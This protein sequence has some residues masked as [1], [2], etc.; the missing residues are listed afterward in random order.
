MKDGADLA[1]LIEDQLDAIQS[2]SSSLETNLK[3]QVEKDNT[4]ML[5]AYDELQK[6]VILLKVDMMQ[7]LSISVDYVDSDGD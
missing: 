4:K 1:S 7:A 2:Q 5:E 6:A 3:S